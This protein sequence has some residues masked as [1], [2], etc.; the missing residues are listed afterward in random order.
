[1]SA[2]FQP[3]RPLPADARWFRGDA[4]AYPQRCSTCDDDIDDDDG[5][6]LLLFRAD[7]SALMRFCRRCQESYWGIQSFDDPDEDRDA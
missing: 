5:P 3:I 6:P 2:P 1:M 7:G 4:P